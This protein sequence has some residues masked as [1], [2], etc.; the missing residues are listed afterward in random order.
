VSAPAPQDPPAHVSLER[1][2]FAVVVP[3]RPPL[4]RRFSWWLLL[5]LVALKPVQF[6][7]AR[8]ART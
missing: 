4:L 3:Q 1:E 2:F 5:R 6:L 7:I 8:R